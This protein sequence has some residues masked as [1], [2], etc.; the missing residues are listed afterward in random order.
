MDKKGEVEFQDLAPGKYDVLA[1][2]R[3]KAYSVVQMSSEAES[4]RDTL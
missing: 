4:S 1:G 3:P 2:S